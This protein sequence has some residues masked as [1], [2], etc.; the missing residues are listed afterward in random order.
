MTAADTAFDRLILRLQ[1]CSRA[2]WASAIARAQWQEEGQPGALGSVIGSEA[3]T[4]T[5]AVVEA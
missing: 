2:G 4:V 3:V 5:A 1:R